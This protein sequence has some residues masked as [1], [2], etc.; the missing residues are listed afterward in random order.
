MVADR[1]LGPGQGLLLGG[2]LGHGD[3][4]DLDEFVDH[5]GGRGARAGHEPGAD[6]VHV[7]RLRAQ[8]GDRVLVE[9]P[10]D[11]DPGVAGAE[12]VQLT[13]D[14]AGEHPQVPGVDADAAESGP[15]DLDRRRHALRDVVGVHQEG[16]VH[17]EGLHLR[18]EGGRLVRTLRAGVQQGERVG[19]RP[20]GGH[21]VPARRLHVGGG[22]EPGEVGGPGRGDRR[23]LVCAAGP[24]LDDGAA[25]RR[26][27]H[28]RGGG[29]DRAVVVEH[30]QDQ[31]LE[32][33]A[34]REPAPDAQHG[35]AGE[36]Q[37]ALRVAVDVTRETEVAEPVG[38]P[39]VERTRQRLD[40]LVVE[41]EVRHA[42][43]EPTGAADHPVPT[44]GGQASGE[45][46]EHT[47]PVGGAVRQGRPDHGE[48]VLVREQGGGR[49]PGGG[50]DMG[51]S[52]RGH[53]GDSTAWPTRRESVSWVPCTL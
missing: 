49:S 53:G 33:D 15:G 23:L 22:G 3:P 9:V 24:H 19:G 16:G 31:G 4:V 32:Y 28:P 43:E 21:A 10:G 30:G 29:G 1:T 12:G 7:D 26:G 25:V 17:T 14:L 51:G 2:T 35:R 44:A 5:A 39:L 48:L 18:A 45:D 11:H 42:F 20:G 37:F 47:R 40:L 8:S 13:A 38:G 50:R 27:G 6:A 46:L 41:P 36:E 52:R 34:L